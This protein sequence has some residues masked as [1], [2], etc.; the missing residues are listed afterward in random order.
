MKSFDLNACGV[1]ELNEM[2]MKS[3][4]GG[5]LQEIKT[6]IVNGFDY[7]EGFCNGIFGIK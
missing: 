4:E 5:F 2:E 6:A 7:V 3:F 1:S